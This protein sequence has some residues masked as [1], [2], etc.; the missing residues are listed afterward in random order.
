M[1]AVTNHNEDRQGAHESGLV[2]WL[3]VTRTQRET[4]GRSTT[5]VLRRGRA[6]QLE[7]GSDERARRRLREFGEGFKR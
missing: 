3:S 4:V 2:V 6:W 7:V 1:A 5:D